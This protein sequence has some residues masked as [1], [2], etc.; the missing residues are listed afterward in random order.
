MDQETEI[1]S[2]KSVTK[3]LNQASFFKK[4][5]NMSTE[6]F[7]VSKKEAKRLRRQAKKDAKKTKKTSS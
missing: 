6:D 4:S 5:D 7:E 2:V 1:E 3:Q